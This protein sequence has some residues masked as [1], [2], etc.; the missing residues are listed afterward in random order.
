MRFSNMKVSSKLYLGFSLPVILMVVLITI[1][2]NKLAIIEN[3]IDL[4]V[5]KNNVRVNLTNDMAS[6]V[7]ENA[8][9]LRNLILANDARKMQAEQNDIVTSKGKYNDMLKKLT[10][11]TRKDD[12]KGWEMIDKIKASQGIAREVNQQ[13]I[14]L[15]LADK[16]KE[17]ID[18]MDAKARPATRKW[19]D[20]IAKA[21]DY[22][23]NLS[24]IRYT[25][26]KKAYTGARL[27]MVV[28]GGVIV[29][30]SGLIAF[31]I[32]RSIVG[33][34]NRVIN[35]LTEGA[36]QVAT[37]A[38][39][40]ASSSQSLAEGSSEQASGIEETTASLEEMSS[41][42]KQNAE[43]AGH[44]NSLMAK[45]KQVVG[46]ATDSMEQLTSSMSEI[47]R[48]SE[49]TQKI[50]KTIDEIAFQTNLLALNAA[51][52]AARAGEAGAG[53]A[54]VADE[55]RNLAMR[56]ADAAKNTASLIEGTVKRVQ[57]GSVLVG[58]TNE[59]FRQLT[60]NVVKSGDLVGE[61]TA[62]S[63]EQAQGI[64]QVNKAV[65]QMDQVV[66]QNA[67]NAEESASASEEM[68]AQAEQMKSIVAELAGMVGGNGKRRP[69]RMGKERVQATVSTVSS[70][71]LLS[72]S[73]KSNGK[74][75]GAVP[76]SP[77]RGIGEVRPEQVI[78]FDD[79]GYS[80]F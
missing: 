3:N 27:F 5:T 14:E 9:S 55:V 39:Q 53:F 73:G 50:I 70:R 35:G 51:V 36:N 65:S 13:V 43:N 44:A 8:I 47:S 23:D 26:A 71:R 4:I 80:D 12:V 76:V 29:F 46:Q 67:A 54:V 56:A 57:E 41:M 22:Q 19:I 38:G 75:N 24:A 61:I 63:Q 21:N 31:L 60:S 18:L 78:P 10:E 77:K 17:A 45:A 37:A 34:L 59:E 2:I 40:V 32:T 49:D 74:G 20:D 69:A 25:E 33:P 6:I 52:E 11:L 79:G 16:E 7:R 58:R 28:I 1:G 48:A 64:D 62:A 72:S 30:L 15:A 42:T 68:S 66:Q